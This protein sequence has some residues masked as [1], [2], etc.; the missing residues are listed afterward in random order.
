VL[1]DACVVLSLYATGRFERILAVAARGAVVNEVVVRESLFV[2]RAGANGR[3]RV[4]V[5]L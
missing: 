1:L 2:Y 4:P 5:E 3:E